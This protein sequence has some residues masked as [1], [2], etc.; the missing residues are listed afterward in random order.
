MKSPARL[1]L[2]SDRSKAAPLDPVQQLTIGRAKSNI[3]CLASQKGV[4]DHHAVVRYSRSQ[5]WLVCNWQ[6]SDGTFLEGR[7]VKR[8]QRLEDG[9]EIRLGLKGP[10]LVFELLDAALPSQT[11]AASAAGV[12]SAP[13]SSIQ[14]GENNLAVAEIRSVAVQS[15]PRNPHVFSWWLL[16]CLGGLLLLPF[17]LVFWPLQLSAL[18]LLIVMGSRKQHLL[19]VVL[20]DGR[21]F[22]H[23]FANLRTALAHRNGIRRAFGHQGSE[24]K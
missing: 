21:A 16:I 20:L 6:S 9:D 11:P 22:R 2:A 24:T 10:V 13:Q 8:C 18:A 5:G 1:V 17:P 15:L 12:A 23:G 3:L 14:L 4:S 7:P 19:S